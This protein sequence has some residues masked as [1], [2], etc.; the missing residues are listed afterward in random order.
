MKTSIIFLY[1]ILIA[2]VQCVA[3]TNGTVTAVK[4]D[5]VVKRLYNEALDYFWGDGNENRKIKDFSEHNEKIDR[6]KSFKL[7]QQCASMDYLPAMVYMYYHYALGEGTDKNLQKGIE[8]LQKGADRGSVECQIELA[9]N[10]YYGRDDD[11]KCVFPRDFKKAMQWFECAHKQGSGEATYML[12][13]MYYKNYYYQKG[14]KY[15]KEELEFALHMKN[16]LDMKKSLRY[17]QEAANLNYATAI[18]ELYF[19]YL[20]GDYGCDKDT[21]EAMSWLRRGANLDDSFCLSEL[22]GCYYLGKMGLPQN[23]VS[24]SF[25]LEKASKHGDPRAMGQLAMMYL[26]GEVFAI[27][28][29]KAFELMRKSASQNDP[30]SQNNMGLMYI[31]GDGCQKDIRL[32]NYWFN[33]CLSNEKAPEDLKEQAKQNLKLCQ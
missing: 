10:Y 11:P 5:S 32:A 21:V 26:N 16:A 4:E 14:S 8:W 9:K 13:L 15:E 19:A 23:S 24:A 20:N 2:A 1:S 6:E 33:R 29:A 7:M 25:Y 31:Y 17:M 22:G 3:Q 30:Y 18:P 27:D 28:K 12:A